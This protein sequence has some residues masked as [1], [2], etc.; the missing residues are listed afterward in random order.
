MSHSP[1]RSESERRSNLAGELSLSAGDRNALGPLQS[2]HANASRTH[3]INIAIASVF[4]ILLGGAA[5]FLGLKALVG[6]PGRGIEGAALLF[7]FFAILPGLGVFFLVRKLS[8]R[9]IVFKNGFVFVRGKERV[10]LWNDV[11]SLFVGGLNIDQHL[12]FLLE[13]GRRLKVD[14]SFKDFPAFAQAARTNVAQRAL[15]R[16]DAALAAGQ[17]VSFGKL[18]MTKSGLEHEGQ[19]TLA[20]PQVESIAIERRVSGN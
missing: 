15:A 20:W 13:D 8:W 14:N 18:K 16:A 2:E 6:P 17:G 12:E 7:A 19:Q 1:R 4:T 9:L 11:K 5:L 10:V 3:K